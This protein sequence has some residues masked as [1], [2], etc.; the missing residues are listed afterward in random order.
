MQIHVLSPDKSKDKLR[1]IAHSWDGMCEAEA[2]EENVGQLECPMTCTRHTKALAE[3]G[4]EGVF[5]LS[6]SRLGARC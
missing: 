3:G 1:L 5:E 6:M 2:C 4:Q